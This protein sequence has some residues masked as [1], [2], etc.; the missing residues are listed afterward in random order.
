MFSGL[1]NQVTS[2][3]GNVKGDEEA[4]APGADTAAPTAAVQPEYDPNVGTGE[5]PVDGEDP[6]RQVFFCYIL[7]QICI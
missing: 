7:F 4:A 3:M 6:K 2:W 5:Q 1:T